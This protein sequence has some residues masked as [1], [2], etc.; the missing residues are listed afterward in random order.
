MGSQIDAE[1]DSARLM[2]RLEQ[3]RLTLPEAARRPLSIPTLAVLFV[4]AAFGVF[5][6]QYEYES[7]QLHREHVLRADALIRDAAG[8]RAI[9]SLK[10]DR[11]LP[12]GE[13]GVDDEHPLQVETR[14]SLFCDQLEWEEDASPRGRS[15][16][17]PK[18]SRALRCSLAEIARKAKVE[19]PQ[20]VRYQAGKWIVDGTQTILDDCH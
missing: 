1:R 11:L 5:L 15:I 19:R 8:E 2:L 3:A 20:T 18:E 4:I 6:I 13:V 14:R 7:G 9:F 12:N 10:A 16:A 17:C